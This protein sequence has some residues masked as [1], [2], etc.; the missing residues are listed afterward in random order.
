DPPAHTRAP[1]P[2]RELHAVAGRVTLYLPDSWLQDRARCE[3][4]G[5]PADVTFATKPQLALQ[6]LERALDAGVPAEW[7]VGDEVYGDD[8]KVRRWLEERWQPYVLA[9]SSQ[10]RIW[11]DLR[12]IKVSE[13]LEQIPTDGWQRLSAGDGAKGPRCYDW[14]YTRFIGTKPRG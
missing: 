10:H 9:V 3:R 14:A 2:G 8:G 11:K 12:Q 13:L 6:M 5:I 4:A 7:V 1:C